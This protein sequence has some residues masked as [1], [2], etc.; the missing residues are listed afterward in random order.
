MT[1]SDC[2]RCK[3]HGTT[4]GKKKCPFPD[5]EGCDICTAFVRVKEDLTTEQLCRRC[6]KLQGTLFKL[7]ANLESIKLMIRGES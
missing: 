4:K 2:N 7:I 1:Y 3:K 6:E 5:N